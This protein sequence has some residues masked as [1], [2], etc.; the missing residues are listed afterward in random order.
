MAIR[1]GQ[2]W[3][4]RGSLAPD[5]PIVGSDR[6]L[7]E[8]YDTVGGGQVGVLGNGDLARTIGARGSEAELRSG[9]ARTCLPV[10]VGVVEIDG[11]SRAF[12]AHVVIR[13][14]LFMGP[15]LIVAN[16]AFLGRWNV[17]P[18]SHPNDGRLELLDAR[19]SLGDALKARRR[20]P[21]GT[22]VPHPD[23]TVRSIRSAELDVPSRSRVYVDGVDCGRAEQVS[24]SVRADAIVV[25]I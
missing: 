4:Y 20:L 6:A 10:D 22:H 8:H 2:D 17:S 18:R 21:S 16:A 24:V 25:V 15:V 3:G 14:P 7:A 11:R 13:R 19:L 5:A 23:I 12:A 9:T 1:K